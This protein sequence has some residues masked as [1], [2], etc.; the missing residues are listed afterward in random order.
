MGFSGYEPASAVPSP[1]M[2]GA[3]RRKAVTSKTLLKI[4]FNLPLMF[5]LLSNVDTQ[6]EFDSP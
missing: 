6:K 5:D 4:Q 3:R 1:H 2:G